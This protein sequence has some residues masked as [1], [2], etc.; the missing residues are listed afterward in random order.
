MSII[1]CIKGKE[2]IVCILKINSYLI[3]NHWSIQWIFQWFIETEIIFLIYKLLK[4]RKLSLR[5][6][7]IATLHRY[8]WIR[9]WYTGRM[10]SYHMITCVKNDLINVCTSARVGVRGRCARIKSLSNIKLSA[11]AVNKPLTNRCC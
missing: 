11:Q 3:W 10:N 5:F 7:C 9:S 4:I 2:T 6:R 8:Q 1:M